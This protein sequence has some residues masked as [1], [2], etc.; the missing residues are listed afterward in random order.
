MALTAKATGNADFEPLSSGVHQAICYG[1][2]DLG[3]QPTNNPQFKPMRKVA[4]L[5]EVPSER[6]EFTKDDKKFNLPRGVSGMWTLSLGTKSKLRPMLESWRGRP[7]TEEEL[8]GFD[9][10]AVLAANCLLNVV[11]AAGK[12]QN[13][14]KTYANVASVNPLVKGMAKLKAE[15]PILWFSLEECGDQIVVP[16]T[17]PDWLKAKIMLSDE[18]IR[19]QQ[20]PNRHQPNEDEMANVSSADSAD[21]DVQRAQRNW[22]EADRKEAMQRFTTK[23]TVYVF[24]AVEMPKHPEC[25][26]SN[27]ETFFEKQRLEKEKFFS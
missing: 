17:V 20:G 9:L 12:G 14:G 24:P 27:F 23:T 6:I 26:D 1:I 19:T 8:S 22:A 10:K 15:N 2:V 18:Y 11:H 21:E 25:T 16:A 4:F 13:S 5:W 7:F 3:T